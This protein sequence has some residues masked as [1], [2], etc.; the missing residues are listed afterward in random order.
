MIVILLSVLVLTD[1]DKKGAVVSSKFPIIDRTA[2][3]TTQPDYIR[4]SANIFEG[5]LSGSQ[6]ISNRKLSDAHWEMVQ[7]R[8]DSTIACYLEFLKALEMKLP[9]DL[10]SA[11]NYQ[12]M[13]EKA[14]CSRMVE[15]NIVQAV[16][17]MSISIRNVTLYG[18]AAADVEVEK[19][20]ERVRDKY[21]HSEVSERIITLL[22]TSRSEGLGDRASG[23][24]PWAATRRPPVYFPPG[25]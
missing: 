21:K 8:N 11:D 2:K 1:C 13:V 3:D 18:D 17:A 25:E 10:P 5:F 24:R 4:E 12:T 16:I 22:N 15:D 6:G 14:G 23:F 9:P 20:L 19:V 7:L